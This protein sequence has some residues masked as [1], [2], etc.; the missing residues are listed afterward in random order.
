M[1]SRAVVLLCRTRRR[2]R[3][4]RRSAAAQR[5]GL[6]AHR[7]AVLL[8]AAVTERIARRACG[9]RADRARRTLVDIRQQLVPAGL[10]ADAVVGQGDGPA[11]APVRGGRGRGPGRAAG[12][13]AAL[14]QADGP[15]GTSRTLLTAQRERRRTQ[16]RTP[17]RTGATA[18][19]SGLSDLRIAPFQLLAAE[20]ATFADRDHGWHL[21]TLDALAAADPDWSPRRRRRWST[22]RSGNSE[23][24]GVAWW[25]ELTGAG[26]E[27]MVV[28][29]LRIHRPGRAARPAGREVPRPR[30]SADHLR[31]RLHRAGKPGSPAPARRSATNGR[32]R[33]ASSRWVEALDRFVSRE[34]LWRVHECV[35]AVLALES[36][37]VDP[38]L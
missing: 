2:P 11:A 26:G 33:C 37:P 12:G 32:W 13:V 17:R 6:H 28:K 10:R 38:R 4:L 31:P 23:A 15:A 22:H 21:D 34:P 1:G 30:L 18:G 36:E 3:A 9:P 16:R 24:A 25:E 20:G 8:R 7:S 5:R 14:A 29:P 27:G 35:F 19:R